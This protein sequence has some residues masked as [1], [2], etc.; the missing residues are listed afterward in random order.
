M[1]KKTVKEIEAER[2]FPIFKADIS[3][4]DTIIENDTSQEISTSNPTPI[5]IKSKKSKKP[6][7]KDTSRI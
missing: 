1:L 5:N 4:D 7:R 6:V 2:R 3:F